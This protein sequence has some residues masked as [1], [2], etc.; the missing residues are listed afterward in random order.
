M[1]AKRLT[2]SLLGL[3]VVVLMTQ[4]IVFALASEGSEQFIT[5]CP[6]H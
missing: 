2:L 1:F 5:I 4:A 3:A 6:L